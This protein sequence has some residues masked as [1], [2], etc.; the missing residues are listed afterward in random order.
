[1]ST[2]YEIRNNAQYNSTEIYFDGKPS[3]EIRNALKALRFRWHGIKKCW[4]GFAT[5]F[6]ISRAI[7]S[8]TPEEE[9]ESTTVYSDGYLGGGAVFGGKSHLGLYGQELKKAIA[10]DIKKAGIKGVTLAMRKGTIY[11]TIRTNPED[12]KPLDEFLKD[13]KL[14]YNQHWIY[15]FDDER[16]AKDIHIDTLISLSTE[17]RQDIT[18][19]AAEFEY[20]KEIQSECSLNE[21]FLDRYKGFTASGM[22]KIKAVNNIIKAYRYDESNAMVDYF[23]TNFYYYLITKPQNLTKEV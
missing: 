19:R 13:Y 9:Q 10:E 16:K 20:Y 3:E 4:Y 1:M 22:A 23:H 15:Y 14:N 7:N 11:A 21:Y 17:E 18:R 6:E 5:D 2:T 8:A 12:I